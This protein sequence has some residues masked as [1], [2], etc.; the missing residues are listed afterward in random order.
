MQIGVE[1]Y[2]LSGSLICIIAQRLAR[3]LCPHCKRKRP[4]TDREKQII[5]H[6]LGEGIADKVPELYD[7]VGCDKCRNTGFIGRL[8]VVEIID[9]DRE[10][11]D[12]IVRQATKK[13]FLKYLNNSG[14]VPMQV[15]GIQ[16]S[17]MGL[18]SVE[19]LSRVV[20]LTEA[21]A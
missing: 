7:S 12:M 14:F 5:S 9:I 15:D 4:I 6:F 16:K 11:D 20:D 17:I 3:R 10:L 18:T 21:L 8:A 1:P 2:L 19:E 13:E